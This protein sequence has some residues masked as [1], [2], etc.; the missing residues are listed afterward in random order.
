MALLRRLNKSNFP[1]IMVCVFIFISSFLVGEGGH[2]FINI[3]GI[4][5][6]LSG[7]IGA[8]FISYPYQNIH[9][10]MKVAVN[11]Y[12]HAAPSTDIIVKGLLE[13][14]VKSHY[15]GILSLEKISE[16][17]SIQFLKN[18]LGLLVDGYK[19]H[20]IRDFLNNEIFFFKQR[21]QQHE[22]IFRHMAILAPAFGVAGSV[23]GIIGMLS[24]IGDTGI[25]LKTIPIALTSTLYGILISNFI[26]TP[27][28]EHIHAK[29]QSELLMQ[30]LVVDGVTAIA[31][32]TDLRKLERK[33]ESFLT[34]AARNIHHKSFEEI[35]KKY[36]MLDLV[37]KQRQSGGKHGYVS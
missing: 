31:K 32:E 24:G 2:T 15:V 17:T 28:A 9:N 10:A 14:S 1:A 25:I 33:L 29:T 19:E 12:K 4:S 36:S 11:S 27:V 13:L 6:V 3:T 8:T 26:L 22:R 35:R 16:Q 20:E 30:K 23:I 18:A 7:T 5:V 34:P 37:E 21:R